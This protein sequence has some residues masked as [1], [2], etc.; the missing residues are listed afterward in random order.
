MWFGPDAP[1][2]TWS[3]A[4]RSAHI[5]VKYLCE[6]CN[7]G[8][9]SDLEKEAQPVIRPLMNDISV[10]L[11]RWQQ[12][13]IALWTIKT[14][15]VFECTIPARERFYSKADRDRLLTAFAPPDGTSM[16][17]G[18]FERSNLSFIQAVRLFG[19][20]PKANAPLGEG[21]VVTFALARLAIQILTV[22][23]KP[24]HRSARV[25]LAVKPG[26]WE[27]KL[28]QI[29]PIKP[30]MYWPPARSFSEE[31]VQEL[32]KRFTNPP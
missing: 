13:L 20:I 3:G 5:R 26:P 7:N 12:Y 24:E 27:R 22:R 21:Y 1:R 19:T 15:M 16:W 9:M 11:D 8:W 10:P 17:L 31:G 28:S 32:C 30:P 29:W 6:T 25:T 2:K 14:A 4:G 18:R 23:R